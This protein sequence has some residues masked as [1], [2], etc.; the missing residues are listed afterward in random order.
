MA[1][2]DFKS[3]LN[4]P[5]QLLF[6]PA[7]N[8]AYLF[9][10][11][12]GTTSLAITITAVVACAVV[13]NLLTEI[14]VTEA[15]EVHLLTTLIFGIGLLTWLAL[16]LVS[17][18]RLHNSFGSSSLGHETLFFLSIGFVAVVASHL[19]LRLEPKYANRS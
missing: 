10:T 18:I 17:L 6:M 8:H 19:V 13:Y 11:T 15:A 3:V 9:A 7:V 12:D 16:L 4:S 1:A 2:S 5:E 14:S